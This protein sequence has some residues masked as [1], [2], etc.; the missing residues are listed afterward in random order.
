MFAPAIISQQPELLQKTK[1]KAASSHRTPK[2]LAS[3]A[4]EAKNQ[5]RAKIR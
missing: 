5:Y 1:W 3:P 2:T 4:S